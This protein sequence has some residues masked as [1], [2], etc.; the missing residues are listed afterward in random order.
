MADAILYP[1]KFCNKCQCITERFRKSECKQCARERSSIYRAKNAEKIKAANVLY[2]DNNVDK[3]KQIRDKWSAENPELKLL[4]SRKWRL[5][6]PEKM[7]EARD[8]WVVANPD[9]AKILSSDWKKKN[10]DAVARYNHNR[11]AMKIAA[12]GKLSCN[13]VKSLFVLQKGL[14]PC[15]G[16]RLGSDYH[17][18][19]IT[20]LYL[21]GTNTD[22]N[23]QL[24]RAECNLQKSKKHP[25]D[26]MQSRGFLL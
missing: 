25:I 8:A 10:Q 12:G 22:D 15:C 16:V 1:S 7:Q 5:N 2:R 4:A 17:L 6:N 14:C 9:K 26:F 20:P 18:D 11:R 19:H 13:I 21:G 3:L 24:L 23:V